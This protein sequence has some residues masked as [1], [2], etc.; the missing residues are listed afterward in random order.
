M[1]I[2]II[3]DSTCDLGFSAEVAYTIDL[4][5]LSVAFGKK[6][7]RDGIDLSIEE[8]YQRLSKASALPTTSQPSPAA[9]AS[10]FRR[11]LDEGKAVLG[12]FLSSALSGTYQS[13]AL[14]KDT[15]SP[16]EQERI[17]LIDSRHA[18]GNLALLVL[19]AC[20]MRD[21][22]SKPEEI[23]E[24]IHSLIPR[25]R[26][27]ATLDSLKY[28]RMGGRLSAAAAVTGGL[29]NIV[30]IVTVEDGA[31]EVAAKI[32]KSR[33]AF[34][35]WLRAKINTDLPDPKYPVFYLY[36][37][38]QAVLTPLQEEFKYLFPADST[39]RLPIGSVIGTHAGP[40]ALGI[41]YVTR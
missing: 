17:H 14:A 1:D 12:I 26:L 41:V 24:H 22:G 33:D 7:Y 31:V 38:N 10:V 21:Q 37:N 39:Y 5:P 34:R 25:V 35:K 23:S 32:R 28:L 29:L 30:P 16:G 9:F 2:A 3:S 13:A 20:R 4:V 11:R 27:Y 36:S 15:F 6:V 19:E 18:T 40:G 8:F